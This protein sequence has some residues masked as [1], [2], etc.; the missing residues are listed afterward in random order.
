MKFPDCHSS[1]NGFDIRTEALGEVRELVETIVL[2]VV[3]TFV[4]SADA[5]R[6][7]HGLGISLSLCCCHRP[8]SQE[9]EA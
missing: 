8:G 2:G 1:L 3:A 5:D 7:V 9:A 4:S 6:L